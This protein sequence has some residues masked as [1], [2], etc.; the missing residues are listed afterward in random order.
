M[1]RALIALGGNLGEVLPRF[2]KARHLLNA[3]PDSTVE[4]VSPY[5]HTPPLGP[6]G[7]PDYLNAVLSLKTTLT[8][9][10]LLQAMQQIEQQLGRIRPTI[11]WSARTIDL[12]LLD[13]NGIIMHSETLELPHPRLHER[14]FVLQ[15]LCDIAPSWQHPLSGLSAQTMLEQ[16]YQQGET[17]LAEGTP[18]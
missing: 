9:E 5:Y 10:A 18:W 13:W 3:L 4:A 8:A 6:P 11:R 15:P 7:Q 1:N 2:I 12:D 17:P 14:L 16:R